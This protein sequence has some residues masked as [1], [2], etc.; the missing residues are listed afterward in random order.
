VLMTTIG[1]IAFSENAGKQ[2]AP[3][4]SGLFLCR[5]LRPA[6]LRAA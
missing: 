6:V 1:R 4:Q 3:N 5:S 2:K